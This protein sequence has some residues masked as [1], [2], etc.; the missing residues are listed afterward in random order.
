MAKPPVVQVAFRIRADLHRR[1]KLYAV[2]SGI[3]MTRLVEQALRD[4]LRRKE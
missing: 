2:K 4:L 1:L 3:P